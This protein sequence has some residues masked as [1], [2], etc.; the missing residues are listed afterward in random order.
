MPSRTNTKQEMLLSTVEL[1]RERGSAAVTIDAILA[2]S[3]APR[4]SVYYHFPNGRGDILAQALDMA[5]DGI[6]SLIEAATVEGPVTALRLFH[7]FW[8]SILRDSDFDAGCPVASVAIGG[9]AEDH[10]L[11]A[12]AAQILDRWQVALAEAMGSAGVDQP[13]AQRMSTMIIASIEGAVMLCRMQKS[14][15]PLD[16]VVEELAARLEQLTAARS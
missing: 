11:K 12:A 15:T 10:D 3:N 4:G 13:G 16:V 7:A 2:R 14:I 9:F 8:A 6:G 1:L 5:G